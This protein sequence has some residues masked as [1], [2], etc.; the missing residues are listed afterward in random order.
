MDDMPS[1]VRAMRRR[2][3]ESDKEHCARYM[4]KQML[5]RGYTLRDEEALAGFE[6]DLG[7]MYP[8]DLLKAKRIISQME[9]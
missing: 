6:G 3:C 9:A 1:L 2:Y 8:N 7:N 5:N 4:I